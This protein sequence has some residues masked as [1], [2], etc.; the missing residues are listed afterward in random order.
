LL[1]I[2][3]GLILIP[4]LLVTLLVSTRLTRSVGALNQAAK[5]YTSGDLEFRTELLFERE[6]ADLGHTLNQMAE[7]LLLR[8]QAAENSQVSLESQVRARTLEL[9]SLNKQL[10]S[11]DR[12]RRQLLADISHE[13][14]TPLTVIQGESEMAL[15][16][17]AKSTEEYRDALTRVREQTLHTARLVDDVLFVARAE[18]GKARIDKQPVV[19]AE[20]LSSVCRDF[21]TVAAGKDIEINDS[22]TDKNAVVV[23]DKG[24]LRQVFSVLLDNAIRYSHV[25]DGIQVDMSLS[26]DDEK[27]EITVTDQG[28]G[29]SEKEAQ[30]A[31]YRFYRGDNAERY[32]EGTGLGLPVAKA[33]V[34]AHNGEIFLSGDSGKGARATVRIPVAN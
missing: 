16:G 15:R 7:E 25:G 29:L 10:E 26:A 24:R 23:V 34:D 22:Y 33:I 30:Q 21:Q 20:V 9:E 1:P 12:T 17:G 6:F 2:A 27:V 3:I 8:R 28:I 31:F 19:L 18:E 13:L 32:A 11:H 14:R 4:G 5:A